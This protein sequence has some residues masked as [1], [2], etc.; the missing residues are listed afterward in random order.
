[1]G[2]Q[3]CRCKD[4]SI[5]EYTVPRVPCEM[6]VLTAVPVALTLVLVL[7][8]VHMSSHGCLAALRAV[9]R[10]KVK[11][12]RKAELDT[13]GGGTVERHAVRVV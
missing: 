2:C 1:M 13:A 6:C 12:N 10:L 11:R 9:E 3:K 8:H 7:V 4:N 5:S